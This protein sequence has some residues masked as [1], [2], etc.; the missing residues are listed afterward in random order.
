VSGAAE[1]KKKLE[2]VWKDADEEFRGVYKL[3]P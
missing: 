1:I 2:V 3:E